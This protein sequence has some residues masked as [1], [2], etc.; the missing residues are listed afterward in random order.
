MATKQQ[1]GVSGGPDSICLLNILYELNRQ[2]YLN[3]KIFVAH[4]NHGLRKN[5]II[6]QNFVNDYCNRKNIP[7]FVKKVDVNKIAKKE[8]RGL[9]ETGR[10]IRY[11]F[12]EEVSKQNDANKIA[13][14]H[15]LNDNAETIIMNIIRGSG[16]S[17]LKGIEPIRNNRYIRPLIEIDRTEIEE[18]CK[19]KKLNPR[20]DES[21]LENN[22]TRNKI[23]NIC[24]PYLKKEF[25]P[26]ILINLN[27]LGEIAR[28]ETNYINKLVLEAYKKVLIAKTDTQIIFSL[29]E[30]NNLDIVIKKKL[31]INTISNL[32]GT[33]KDIQKI[34]IDDIIK[35]CNKNIGN[36]Y[37]IPKK[38]VKI[39][40]KNKKIYFI[41]NSKKILQ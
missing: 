11:D 14:A 41:S 1:F 39:L 8:N 26:N 6:D 37:L 25:N 22:Y 17:G 10:K 30:F 23:R 29:K 7:F 15:N 4:I 5:A 32:C 28:E 18:Y 20:I 36:K 21:N 33:S 35:L 31:I 38:Y 9:E 3:F 34:N 2:G 24:I 13:I 27:R 16:I 12:F 40:V 19:E